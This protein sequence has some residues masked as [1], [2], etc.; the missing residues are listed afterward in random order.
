MTTNTS[1]P[2]AE[3][4]SRLEQFKRAVGMDT[5]SSEGG[6]GR[7]GL[8]VP[9]GG[10]AAIVESAPEF[11]ATSNQVCG[12]WPFP[13]G[14]SLPAKGVP[15]GR[16]QMMM[17]DV[18]AD[19]V[20][21]FRLGLILNPSA[22]ILGRP[23]LGKS[24]LIRR[25]LTV[26]SAWGVIPMILSDLKPD[27][28]K[29]VRALGGEAG[30]ISLGRG[31]SNINPLDP[32]P[33]ASLLPHLWEMNEKKAAE[34]QAQLQG[35][36][37][38]TLAGLCELVLGTELTVNELT[39][40]R[41]ALTV[42]DPDLSSTPVVDDVRVLIEERNDEVRAVVRDRGDTDRY[43]ARV[44]RLLDAL[45]GLGPKGPFGDT[46]A[47]QTSVPMVLDRPVVFDMSGVDE[48]DLRMQAALQLVC[49]SYGS[50]VVQGAKIKA[51]AGLGPERIYV[52]VM[53]EL[54]RVLRASLQMVDRIDAITRLN[55]QLLLPQIMCTHTMSDLKLATEEATEKAWGFVERSEMVF[56]GGLAPKEMG[57][58]SEVFAMP[59]KER[60]M[61]TT[62]SDMHTASGDNDEDP[63][64]RG[65][66]LLKLGSRPGIPF[67]VDLVSSEL[68]VNDT[69]ERWG[70]YE[71]SRRQARESA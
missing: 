55:R 57:N 40:L 44:E 24:T 69:N 7:R 20:T 17:M 52:L 10:Y 41:A 37:L 61:L 48:D 63:P 19:P 30:V 45:Q 32:G 5:T 3:Q 71:E 46:F 23:G 33:G 14:S 22:F 11:E 13:A 6:P 59:E 65:L 38:N 18:C 54:W 60:Q 39:I 2:T 42:L 53:D 21:W 8:K 67:R 43:D 12:L 31:R 36:R 16:H 49:W 47:Q 29:L 27:Y 34:V 56:L 25:M 64:G 4:V 51:E 50:A 68:A 15:L 58:L 28:V 35:R 1:T 62:W 9:G 70:A 26:L 66:F